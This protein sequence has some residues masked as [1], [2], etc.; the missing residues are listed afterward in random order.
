MA[1]YI[2]LHLLI[3]LRGQ[4]ARAKRTA[5]VQQD[6]KV[7]KAVSIAL[8]KV[9]SE[10]LNQT[11]AAAAPTE[12]M[13]GLGTFELFKGQ[14]DEFYFRLKASNGRI[15]LKS[16]GYTQKAGASNGIRSVQENG[17]EKERFEKRTNRNGDPYFVLKAANGHITGMSEM[18]SSEQARDNGIESVMTFAASAKV[19]LYA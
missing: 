17:T 15:I 13:E 2:S 1:I 16:E 5:R 8:P 18:Y 4:I 14:N 9:G 19:V 10:D 11:K 6:L 7:D 3:L 12:A